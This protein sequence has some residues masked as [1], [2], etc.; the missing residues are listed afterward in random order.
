ML[1]TASFLS[2]FAGC[3]RRPGQVAEAQEP[4]FPVSHPVQRDVTDY[5]EF[6]GR[7]NAK[8]AVSIQ[9]RVTGFLVQMPFKEG[10]NVKKGDLLFEIDP[11]P[12]QAQYEA[13]EAQVALNEAAKRYAV[14]TNERFKVLRKKEAGAVS[15]RE[16]DQYQ[17]L[18]D[19]ADAT[20]KLAKANL[21]SAKLNLDWTKV[22]SPIDGRI[23]R[24]YLT[25]GNLVNQDVTQLTTLVS[26][27]PM[28]VY[29]DMDESTFMR[30]NA[31]T[32]E[33]TPAATATPVQMGVQGEP[34]Y[35]HQGTINFIDNQV[36]PATGSIPVRGVFPNAKLPGG[37]QQL[38]PGMFVRIHLPI[39][40]SHP[41]LLVID[42]AVTSD[43]DQK[44]VYVFDAEKK[45]AQQRRVT[46][47]PLQD[48]GLRVITQGLQPDDWVVVG[49][50]QQIRPRM[51][52]QTDPVTMPSYTN[53]AEKAAPPAASPKTK[54]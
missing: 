12:Y 11:R 23:S 46:T 10:S 1:F 40:Q 24:Y 49:G 14:A 53:P 38:V 18:E 48:D 44:Y 39:G 36:N 22:S 35:P 17:A 41:A 13:A 47:G 29:F 25:N 16:L 43:Q 9:P 42:R 4:T 8:D 20:L 7:T 30:F 2:A 52:I 32:N 21:M 50:L 3:A 45:E 54:G 31:A 15:D 27:D 26:M 6:T 37:V 19:Q 51:K 28:Y 33:G 5:V 34:G